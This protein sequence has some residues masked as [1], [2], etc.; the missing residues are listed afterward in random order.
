MTRKLWPECKLNR[1]EHLDTGILDLFGVW[2]L[3]F[4]IYSL[5]INLRPLKNYLQ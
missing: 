1:F 5:R 2:Y 4:E 3:G